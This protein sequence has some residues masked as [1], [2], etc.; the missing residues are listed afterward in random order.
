MNKRD[1][2]MTSIEILEPEIIGVTESWTNS[3][4]LEGEISLK[5]YDLFRVDRENDTSG[6]GVL[7]YI[8]SSLNATQ[9]N[10]LNCIEAADTMWCLVKL[11]N[12]DTLLLGICYRSTSSNSINNHRMFDQIRRCITVKGITHLLIMGDFNFPEINWNEYS[13]EGGPFSDQQ[14]FFDLSQDLFLAQHV[15]KPTRHR[16][17][18]KSSMLDLIFHQR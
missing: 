12:S 17:G 14:V 11:N 10:E 2:F 1:E 18:Q 7:L 16:A 3:S 6:G 9:C 15:E 13:V 4:V 8:H 5:G